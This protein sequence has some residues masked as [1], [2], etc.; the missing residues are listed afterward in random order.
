MTVFVRQQQRQE[1]SL[2]RVIASPFARFR[3]RQ[4]AAVPGEVR[5][6]T[7]GGDAGG[8]FLV[9][10]GFGCVANNLAKHPVVDEVEIVIE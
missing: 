8:G 3:G 4:R 2:V 6:A 10:G 7:G 1:I 5:S 9:G